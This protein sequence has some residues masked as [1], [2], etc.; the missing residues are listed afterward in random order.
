M[1]VE[2]TSGLS[3]EVYPASM[4]RFSISAIRKIAATSLMTGSLFS[5]P[6]IIEKQ[7]LLNDSGNI[8]TSF[9]HDQM[10]VRLRIGA[11]KKERCTKSRSLQ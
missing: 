3:S 4:A 9:P 2:L 7:M 1:T 8:I 11:V 6:E 5:C 10:N